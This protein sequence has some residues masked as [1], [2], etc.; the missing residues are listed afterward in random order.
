MTTAEIRNLIAAAR[1]AAR[2]IEVEAPGAHLAGQSSYGVEV[3]ALLPEDEDED[4]D[5]GR[6]V[7]LKD[8]ED[9]RYPEI[10]AVRL[11][12]CD[13]NRGDLCRTVADIEADAKTWVD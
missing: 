5:E 11:F 13:G 4:E 10:K 2:E 1:S 6:W 3:E 12:D 7:R 8:L 9:E